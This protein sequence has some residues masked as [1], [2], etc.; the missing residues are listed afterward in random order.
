M[1]QMSDV[2]EMLR[3]EDSTMK[4][5]V[6]F[7]GLFAIGL[8]LFSLPLKQL[9]G[10]SME[11]ELY[12]HMPLI[13]LVSLYFFFVERKRIFSDTG[14]SFHVGIPFLV[15]GLVFYIFGS[16]HQQDYPV[17]NYLAVMMF[18]FFLWIIAAFVV[19]YGVRAFKAA[20]FPLV[21][22]IFLVPIPHFILDP[23]IR[24]LQNWSAEAAYGVFKTIGVPLH[25]E[26][27]VFSL[28]GLTVEV[29]EQCSGIRSSL[30]L[31]I[32]SIVAGKLFLET[33]WRRG[34]L[35]LCVF[36]IAVFKNGLRI[37]TISLLAA[38]VDPVFIDRHW[39]HSSGGIPFFFVALLLLM[40][41]VWVM[42]RWEK[43]AESSKLKVRKKQ[44][45][46]H[47]PLA[48]LVRDAEIAKGKYDN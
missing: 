11:D 31:F 41:V 45:N 14:Y 40:P 4:R 22:L 42:R 10:L 29:A 8:V 12:S 34:I 7:A 15:L 5:G 16:R 1:Q 9:F 25:R 6:I 47:H 28:P 37:V 23:Y 13:P 27:F 17:N 44:K 36:P 33:K 43:R 30:A 2:E 19:S 46:I 18:G 20:V 32:T 35:A 39:I 24:F 21:F 48:S 38:Y 3:V 26:G